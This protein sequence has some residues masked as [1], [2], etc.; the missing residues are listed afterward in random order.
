MKTTLFSTHKFEEPHL[1]SANKGKH[2]LNLL[3]V[4]LT[5]STASLAQ[6]SEAI[7]L[8][9]SDDGHKNS[10]CPRLFPLCHSRTHHGTDTCIEPKINQ[11]SQ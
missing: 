10:P 1:V 11:G 8:F 3:E 5:E 9:T 7:S 2:E 4:R 6:G